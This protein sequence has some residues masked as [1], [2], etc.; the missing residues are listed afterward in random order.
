MNE[1]FDEEFFDDFEEEEM[2]EKKTWFDHLKGIGSGVVGGAKRLGKA[3]VDNPE[4]ALAAA[5]TAALVLLTV[6]T[7]SKASK[8]AYCDEIGESVELKKKLTN[9]NKAAIDHLMKSEGMTKL[10]AMETLGLTK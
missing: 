4:G 1:N 5:G 7:G 2:K 10:Q 9:D 8:L 6:S 3:I